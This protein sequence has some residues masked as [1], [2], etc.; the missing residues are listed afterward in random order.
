MNGGAEY[1]NGDRNSNGGSGSVEYGEDLIRERLARN[2][3]FFGEE[4]SGSE[5]AVIGC[6]GMGSWAAVMLARSYVSSSLLRCARIINVV[7]SFGSVALRRSSKIRLVD[8]DYV[9]LSSLNRHAAAGLADMGTPKV[10]CLESALGKFSGWVEIDLRIESWKK[11]SP[12]YG[13]A[14][15]MVQSGI[16]VVYSTEATGDVKL[17]PLSEE[18]FQRGNVKELGVLEDPRV[19]ILGEET[20]Y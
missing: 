15:S 18:G 10:K 12:R 16:P 2:Y 20:S 19:R 8:F 3:A 6:G 14:F 5:A 13:C 7:F 17:L 11:G 4:G 1:G 9:T